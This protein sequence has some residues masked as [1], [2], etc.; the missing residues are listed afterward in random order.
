ME[1]TGIPALKGVWIGTLEYRDYQ[2]DSRQRLATILRITPLLDGKFSFRYVYD[3]G[4]KKVIQSTD[5]ITIESGKYTEK[6]EDGEATARALEGLERLAPDGTGTL[7]LRG[8]NIDNGVRVATRT[9]VR[10]GKATLSFRK[11]FQGPGG[12]W[13]FRNEYKLV[14][15][16]QPGK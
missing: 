10:I 4:P 7:V 1:R 11:E 6:P 3:D 9:T 13:E 16:S 15:V 12:K 2:D 8:E 14:R 5:L